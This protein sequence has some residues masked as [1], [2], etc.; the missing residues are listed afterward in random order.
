V[1]ARYADSGSTGPPP[2]PFLPMIAPLA[3]H[4]Q[5]S[6]SVRVVRPVRPLQSRGRKLLLHDTDVGVG[7]TR[8]TATAW[9]LQ[10]EV[11]AYMMFVAA[12]HVRALYETA[13]AADRLSA[14][15]PLAIELWNGREDHWK[16]HRLA[17]LHDL[18]RAP[19]AD[20]RPVCM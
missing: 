18:L 17:Y 1:L 9:L 12:M 15:E 13:A 16:R 20:E 5:R 19:S 3:K 7:G 6:G 8:T 2:L 11:A 10:V 14:F 4:L